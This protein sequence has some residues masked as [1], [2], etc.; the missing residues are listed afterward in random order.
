MTS[1]DALNFAEFYSVQT[2]CN[3]KV[4]SAAFEPFQRRCGV[5]TLE[6]LKDALISLMSDEKLPKT[7]GERMSAILRRAR[8]KREEL[9]ASQPRQDDA[10]VGGYHTFCTRCKDGVIEVPHIDD[11]AAEWWKGEHVMVV[12][13]MC[14]R[15][16]LWTK[17]PD[18]DFYE[19]RR[20]NW[21]DEYPIRQYEWRVKI[22]IANLDQ[23]MMNPHNPNIN[24][25]ERSLRDAN[26]ELDI[27]IKSSKC[28]MTIRAYREY[29]LHNNGQPP[30]PNG[31]TQHG[32]EEEGSEG[33]SSYGQAYEEDANH[34]QFAG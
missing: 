21:K 27:Y 25:Y 16:M 1:D 23:A 6:E 18:I 31:V 9:L 12:R 14:N 4:A 8:G 30:V 17:L 10:S 32:S 19:R 2:N 13:C 3:L 34:P 29:L 26:A 33:R 5:S 20:P 24:H 28:G 15:G 7:H 11:Y 22:A